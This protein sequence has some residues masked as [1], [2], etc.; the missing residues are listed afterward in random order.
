[1]KIT[2]L[3]IVF[4]LVAVAVFLPISIRI[5]NLYAL[6][7]KKVEYN[8]SLDAAVDDAV[9]SLVEIDSKRELYLNKIS[10]LERFYGSLYAN[11]GVMDSPDRQE[12]LRAYIPVI[13]VTFQ[14]GYYI[15]YSE[16]VTIEG[17]R[18]V[19]QK[20]TEKLPYSYEEDGQI[21]IFTLSNYLRLYDKNT[22]ELIEGTNQD[23]KSLCP[24]T[25]L[26]ND[27]EFDQK[28][29]FVITEKIESSMRYYINR[30]NRIAEHYGITYE[31]T[32]PAIESNDWNR[33]IDDISMLV[34]FQGYPYGY[35]TYDIYNR[36]AFGA[37]RIRKQDAYYIANTIEGKRYYHK[38]NCTEVKD[39]QYAYFS[40][41]E[42][43]LEGAY[44]CEICKP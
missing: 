9:R 38:W 2:N 43:A 7:Q 44:A 30:H 25:F 34:I 17:E 8:Q 24:N 14:D 4:F 40:K 37:A 12:Q 1:M 31:F 28:R 13:L 3:A 23:L 33:T 22:N 26:E 35:G 19:V 5:Q 20:W 32:L 27:E 18:K 42:C 21:Y 16:I 15:L 10:G 36:Y 41:K 6:A 39:T 11:F 29:R